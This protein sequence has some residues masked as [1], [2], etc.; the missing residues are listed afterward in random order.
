M[1]GCIELE[2]LVI[3]KTDQDISFLRALPKLQRLTYETTGDQEDAMDKIKSAEQFWKEYDAKQS[4]G[5]K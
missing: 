5:K 3:P 2:R 1:A 4:A